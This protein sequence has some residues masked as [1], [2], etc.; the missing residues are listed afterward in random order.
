MKKTVLVLFGGESTEHEVSNKS[1]YN[2]VNAM[3]RDKYDIILIGI[4]KDGKWYLYE[5]DIENIKDGSWQLK[6]NREAVISP[7]KSVK[8]ITV[9]NKDGSFENIKTDVCFPVLHGKNGE[10]GTVQGLLELSGINFVGGKTL[11]MAMCMDKVITK[12][13][14][15][16]NNIPQTPY[17]FLKKND[18][19]FLKLKESKIK[20]PLFV[21]PVNAGS[22]IGASKA[23]DESELEKAVKEAFLYDD[24]VLVEKNINCREIETAVFGNDIL[25]VAGPGEIISDSQFYDYNTKYISNDNVGYQI[26]ADITEEQTKLIIDYAKK[27]YKA[28]ECRSLSRVDFFIDKDTGEIYLNEI[29]TLPGF[30]N[31]S[32]YPKL[33]ISAGIEYGK[34]VDLLIETAFS[35][36]TAID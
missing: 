3:N 13:I 15:E 25:S 1:A 19:L 29:N 11:S 5:G 4:T 31:I 16:K 6:D 10:D 9:F 17:F 14:L 8:G 21:K 18:D 26:P 36:N 28:L 32:M 23:S 35:D 33:F 34:L 20:F 30:T 7:S 2:V 22:S 24:K 12:I 27:A